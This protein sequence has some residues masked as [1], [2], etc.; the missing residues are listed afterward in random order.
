MSGSAQSRRTANVGSQG[1][2]DIAKRTADAV[3]H[4]ET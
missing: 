3:C 2:P 4:F 1:R